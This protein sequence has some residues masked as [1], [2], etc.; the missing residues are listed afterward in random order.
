M[1]QRPDHT[2]I[3]F[4]SRTALAEAV[5]KPLVSEKNKALK[6]SRLVI[7][8]ARRTALQSGLPVFPIDER[9]QRGDTFGERLFNAFDDIFQRG[10]DRVIAIGNDCLELTSADLRTAALSLV[11]RS[12]IVGKATDGGVYLLG[13]QRGALQAAD[14]QQIHWQTD[15][16]FTEILQLFDGENMEAGLLPEKLDV[17]SRASLLKTLNRVSA[18]LRRAFLQALSHSPALPNTDHTHSMLPGFISTSSLR[19]PPAC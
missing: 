1:S 7:E 14:F 15:Q 17:D 13:L 5:A 16:V 12:A 4:F 6:V 2:A 8:T 19:G 11:H 3:L 18:R 10:F 9:Q